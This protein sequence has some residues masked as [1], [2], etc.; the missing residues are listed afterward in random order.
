K[1][2]PNIRLSY[3]LNDNDSIA[4]YYTSRVDR[5]GEPELR[6]FPKYD[7]PELLKVGNPYLRPQFTKSMELSYEHLWHSGSAIL[8]LYHRNID[9]PFQRVLAIDDSNPDYSIINR[10]Y[11]NV[12]SAK[13]D[14]VE[15]I[16]SQDI[17][18]FWQL[19]GSINWY[20]NTIDAYETQLLFPVV[21]PF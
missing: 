15:L 2:Y 7:D 16:L 21:R 13:N 9:D 8:S 18:D 10:I 6:I 19:S 20:K 12:G 11:Q 1:L 3:K 4:A 17:S 14:G 5:P